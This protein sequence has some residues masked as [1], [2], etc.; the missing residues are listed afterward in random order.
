MLP[1][2]LKELKRRRWVLLALT[3]LGLIGSAA[4]NVLNARPTLEAQIIALGPPVLFFLAFEVASRNPLAKERHISLKWMLYLVLGAL[5]LLMGLNSFFHQRSAFYRES[6]DHLTANTLPIA[7]DCFMLICAILVLELEAQIRDIKSRMATGK[8][9][10]EVE[11]SLPAPRPPQEPKVT[12]R[13]K[14]AMFL[15]KYPQADVNELV[16]KTGLSYNY[17]STLVK[18]MRAM[19]VT[20]NA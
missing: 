13:E 12:G 5:G 10:A 8:T 1:N 14:V 15:A 16:E 4:G 3:T 17:V 11:K 2:K 6:G 18:Q 7:I 20:A 19:P 9:A